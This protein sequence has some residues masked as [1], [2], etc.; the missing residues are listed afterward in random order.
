MKTY[1]STILL[2]FIVLFGA[3]S[4]G[5]EFEDT[6]KAENLCSI[7][8]TNNSSNPYTCYVN[9]NSVFRIEGGSSRTYENAP[10]GFVGVTMEQ[11]SGYV[12]YATV[13]SATL[14]IEAC[15]NRGF[16]N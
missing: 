3:C 2:A 1:I 12:F 8:F 4:K 16:S 6:C 13:K 5:D 11:Y 7:T 10:A 14:Q 9:N 15:E